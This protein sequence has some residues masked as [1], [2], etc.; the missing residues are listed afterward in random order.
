MIVDAI[1]RAC[2][3]A[4][5]DADSGKG[6]GKGDKDWV[7]F[8]GDFRAI[9]P[10]GEIIAAPRCHVPGAFEDVLY[11]QVSE[12]METNSAVEFAIRRRPICD[13]LFTNDR[14]G[15]LRIANL[16][17]A[18]LITNG[19]QNLFR[20]LDTHVTGEETF[21]KLCKKSIINLTSRNEECAH[22]REHDL[23]GLAK[24][25]FQLVERFGKESHSY[26][27]AGQFTIGSGSISPSARHPTR[28]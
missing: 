17:E 15:F 28:R 19:R 27:A 3:D 7:Q 24:R 5:A 22:I 2:A 10:S 16:A 14:L 25:A 4:H 9:L 18:P 11:N 12:A 20:V 21:L 13:H 23:A 6:K 8:I 1:A 26:V